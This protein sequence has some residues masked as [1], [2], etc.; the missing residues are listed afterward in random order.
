[1]G[2]RVLTVWVGEEERRHGVM[3]LHTFD[4]VGGWVGALTVWVGEEWRWW[5][6][7]TR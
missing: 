5:K 1:V 3:S 7:G 4:K 2:G 6:D